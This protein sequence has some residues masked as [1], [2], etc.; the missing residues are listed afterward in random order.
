[1]KKRVLFLCTSNRCRSQLAEA[2]VNHDLSDRFAA[3]SA[4]TDP[5]APHPLAIQVLAEIGIDHAAARSK[6]LS[7]F[8]GQPF[9]YV[10]TLC[11]NANETCPVFFGGTRRT[12][13]GVENPDEATGSEEERLAVFR[14]V[15]D[16]LRE[17]AE[18]Y[19]R[20]QEGDRE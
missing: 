8:D 11:D 3:F 16:W 20:R 19:L 10:I 6:H 15:R 12:H 2:L 5:K 9:D 18:T 13:M 4:G 17:N 1:M 7:E 14:R